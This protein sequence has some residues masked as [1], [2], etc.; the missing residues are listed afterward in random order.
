MSIKNTLKAQRSSYLVEGEASALTPIDRN[1]RAID[2]LVR[3]SETFSEAMIEDFSCRPRKINLVTA[4]LPK[5][6]PFGGVVPSS[7]GACN[8]IEGFKT[9]S[10]VKSVYRPT[11]RFNV[12][13]LVGMLPPYA[14]TTEKSNRANIKP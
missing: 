13:K 2:A 5:D 10:H 11:N 6:L 8:S 12:A 3:H 4:M 14:N 7:M 9:F 1:Y